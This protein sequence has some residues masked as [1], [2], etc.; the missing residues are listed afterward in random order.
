MIHTVLVVL[1]ALLLLPAVLLAAAVAILYFR[2]GRV[3][4]L[5]LH[6]VCLLCSKHWRRNHALLHATM[7][8]LHEADGQGS[9]QLANGG[10][11]RGGF[12]IT[13]ALSGPEQVRRAVDTARKRLQQGE[14]HLTRV[15]TCREAKTFTIATVLVAVWSVTVWAYGLAITGLALA[16]LL[17]IICARTTANRLQSLLVTSRGAGSLAVVGVTQTPVR[18]SAGILQIGSQLLTPGATFEVHTGHSL[19][20]G[21]DQVQRVVVTRV[22]ND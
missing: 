2:S 11:Q 15:P 6:V 10:L 4:M 20:A 5:P 1:L 17:A 3:W 14:H 16:G 19:Q 22:Q 13:G 12:Y 8:V 7:N 18:P 9:G 21:S